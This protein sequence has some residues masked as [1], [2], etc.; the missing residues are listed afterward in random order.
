[1]HVY[2][3]GHGLDNN[4]LDTLHRLQLHYKTPRRRAQICYLEVT[5]LSERLRME[6]HETTVRKLIPCHIIKIYDAH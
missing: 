4:I 5:E 3:L 2:V 1:M 6:L